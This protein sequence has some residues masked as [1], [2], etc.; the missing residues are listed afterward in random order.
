MPYALHVDHLDGFV[1]DVSER[2]DGMLE[3]VVSAASGQAWRGAGDGI[4]AAL[5]LSR[6][7]VTEQRVLRAFRE[8]VA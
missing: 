8:V 7:I 2:A 5:D 3:V 4:A 1:S 6:R